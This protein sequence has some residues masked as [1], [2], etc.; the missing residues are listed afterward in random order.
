MKRIVNAFGKLNWGKRACAVFALIAMSVIALP[1]QTFTTLFSFGG[2][3]GEYP[4]IAP[5]LV[6]ATNGY[7]YGT[8]EGGGANYG[9][10]VF[11]I[12]PSGTLTTLYSF[13]PKGNC[14]DGADPLAGLVQATNGDFYGTTGGGGPGGTVFKITPSGTLTTL[15]WFC[16]QTNCTDGNNPESGLVQATNGDIY[17]TTYDGGANGDYGTVFRITPGGTLTTL[18]SFCSQPNCTDGGGPEAGLVQGTDGN[19]YGTTVYGGANGAGTVFRITPSGTL[20]TLHSFDGA[21]G[22]G[23]SFGALVQWGLLRDNP[24]WRDKLW[25]GL[26]NHREWHAD[27]AAQLRLRGRRVPLRWAGPGHRRQLL[28]DNRLWW[29]RLCLPRL[30]DGFRDHAERDADDAVQLLLPKRLPGRPIPLCAA[31]PGH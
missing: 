21:D 1:A 2:T 12:T 13:C 9:G 30:R 16:S 28:R 3:K 23:P 11:K 7:L 20:T 29:G 24:Q 15:Y 10:T 8:T 6:Q 5:W 25:H 4:Y 26:R 14:A 18:Y 27:H 31:R 22:A 17:G 19:L